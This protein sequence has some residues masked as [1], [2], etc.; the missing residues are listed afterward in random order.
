MRIA[1]YSYSLALPLFLSLLFQM[2]NP[3]MLDDVMIITNN[4]TMMTGSIAEGD[5]LT[6]DDVSDE[7]DDEEVSVVVVEDDCG[8]VVVGMLVIVDGAFMMVKSVVDVSSAVRPFPSLATTL[9]RYV[10]P[11]GIEFV[12][13]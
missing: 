12:F 1:E 5:C 2:K 4:R 10:V 7:V 11:S 13:H 9:T 8:L 3:P 6:V